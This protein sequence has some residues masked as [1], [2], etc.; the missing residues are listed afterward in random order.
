MPK[1]APRCPEKS[2]L[3]PIQNFRQKIDYAYQ[4]FSLKVQV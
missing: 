4:Q 2:P 1:T 3:F